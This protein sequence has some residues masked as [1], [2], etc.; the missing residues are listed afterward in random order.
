M[1]ITPG[2]KL[3][4]AGTN[5][6]AATLGGVVCEYPDVKTEA[7]KALFEKMC[8]AR[9]DLKAQLGQRALRLAQG[10]EAAEKNG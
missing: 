5:D 3:D 8:A 4:I 6:A 10:K 9:P 7:G 1:K 2:E